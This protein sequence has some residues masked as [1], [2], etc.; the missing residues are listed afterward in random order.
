[1][2]KNVFK[3]FHIAVVL[4]AAVVLFNS[5]Y[6]VHQREYVA[7]RQFGKVIAV[8]SEPGLK[9]KVPFIQTTQNISA[10]QVL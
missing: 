6:V 1:M 3:A 9:V 8:A 7:V 5:L 4:V 10:A 2:K